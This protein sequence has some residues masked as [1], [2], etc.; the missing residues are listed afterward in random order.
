M[1]IALFNGFPCHY[2]M[3]GYIIYFCKQKGYS[4]MIYH[5]NNKDVQGYINFYNGMFADFLI[6]YKDISLFEEEKGLMDYIFLTTDDDFSYKTT[7]E[8]TNQKTICIDHY[9]KIRNPIFE[10]RIA[11]RPFPKGYERKWALPTYPIINNDEKMKI[12]SNKY[13]NDECIIVMIGHHNGDFYN[14]MILNQLK[15]ENNKIVIHAISPIYI[16]RGNFRGLDSS[17]ELHI[18]NNIQTKEM[19]FILYKAHYVITGISKNDQIAYA[20]SGAIP[21]AFSTLTPLIIC[22]ETNKFYQFKNVIEYDKNSTDEIV[23]DNIDIE[24]LEI[25][26]NEL[27]DKN[28]LLLEELVS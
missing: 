8:N 19:I 24:K 10:K 18:H 26:R 1:R 20:M 17:I 21:L 15:K 2:E 22:N 6:E 4:L 25:E 27:L 23:L 11:T 28:K 9:Y 12:L 3:Y 14:T 5:D 16:S 7:D 13:H